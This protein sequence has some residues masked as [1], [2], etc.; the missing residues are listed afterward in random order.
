MKRG[1]DFGD[2][3]LL[4]KKSVRTC[5]IRASE[6]ETKILK[7]D[8]KTFMQYIGELT[9]KSVT[10]IIDF[11]KECPLFK[12]L[13]VNVRNDLASRSFCSKYPANTIII[14]QEETPFNLF[15]IKKGQ[16]RALRKIDKQLVDNKSV[17]KIFNHCYDKIPQKMILQ[18]DIIRKKNFI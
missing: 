1:E 3:A 17:P 15:F 14:K 5:T 16:V 11:Y 12:S 6:N 7:L 9:T 4:S 2:L 18:V 13:P 10:A 8:K